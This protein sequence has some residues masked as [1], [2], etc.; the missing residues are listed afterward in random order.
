[1]G[2]DNK[3]RVKESNTRDN[4]SATQWQLTNTESLTETLPLSSSHHKSA[5]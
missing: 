3:H 5:T 2:A 1:M 4:N